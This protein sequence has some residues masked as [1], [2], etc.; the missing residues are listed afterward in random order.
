MN[1]AEKFAQLPREPRITFDVAHTQGTEPAKLWESKLG[2]APYLPKGAQWPTRPVPADYTESAYSYKRARA[3]AATNGREPMAFIAQIN[4]SDLEEWRQDNG[5]PQILN[6]H[7]PTAGMLQF[8][9]PMGEEFGLLDPEAT[10]PLGTA[11]VQYWPEFVANE[12]AA[13]PARVLIADDDK[14]LQFVDEA[15]QIELNAI[16]GIKS[17][18]HGGWATPLEQPRFPFPLRPQVEAGDWPLPAIWTVEVPQDIR[19]TAM[20]LQTSGDGWTEDFEDLIERQAS[21][22]GTQLGGHP[23]FTQKDPREDFDDATAAENYVLLFALDAGNSAGLSMGDSGI[24]NFLIPEKDLAA[25]DLRRVTM[26]WDC[27]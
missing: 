20:E 10:G 11:H 26:T 3:Q 7:L 23:Y 27:L 5:V 19:D 21:A 15:T 8:Y 16:G 25:W 18:D 12:Q 1:L 4:L 14:L 22:G 13:E 24:M 6:G 2:G 9:L 17:L